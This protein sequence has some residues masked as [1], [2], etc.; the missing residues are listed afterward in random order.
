[1]LQFSCNEIIDNDVSVA[2][3][4]FQRREKISALA[5]INNLLVQSDYIFIKVY[6]VPKGFSSSNSFNFLDV[7]M[8]RLTMFVGAFFGTFI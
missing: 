1:M 3:S 7:I 2:S 6:G 5:N 8:W 4:S